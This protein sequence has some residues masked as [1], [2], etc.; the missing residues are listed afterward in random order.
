MTDNEIITIANVKFIEIWE[1]K[2]KEAK[3]GKLQ[4][5]IMLPE[6]VI[7]LVLQVVREVENKRI[8]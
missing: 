8:T 1:R 2:E 4:V 7:E 6:A 3:E 5:S